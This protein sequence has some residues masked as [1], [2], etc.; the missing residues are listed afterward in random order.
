MKEITLTADKKNWSVP[1]NHGSNTDK[2]VL[3]LRKKILERDDYTC[4]FCGFRAKSFQE[5]HHVDQNHSNNDERN[6]VCIC[7]LCHQNFHLVSASITGGGKIIWLP[8]FSQTSLNHLCRTIFILIHKEGENPKM[9]GLARTVYAS[10]DARAGVIENQYAVGASDCGTFAQALIKIKDANK[11]VKQKNIEHFK[12]L[13]C[14]PRFQ[15]A[16]D[17]WT[18]DMYQNLPFEKWVDLVPSDIDIKELYN[19]LMSS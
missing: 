11:E 12:M 1:V 13:P 15:N 9:G 19:T 5:I 17:Y 14:Y 2:S 10:L 3:D 4:N 6:L 7:P 8:E 16:V 18:K